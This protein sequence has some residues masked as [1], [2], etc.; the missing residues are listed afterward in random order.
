MTEIM[1]YLNNG[2]AVLTLIAIGFA[3]R[4]AVLWFGTNVV[5]PM[6]DAALSH[7]T[8]V[9]DTMKETQK[10]STESCEIMKTMHADVKDIKIHVGSGCK[11]R[12]RESG[13]SGGHH[14]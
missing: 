10:V 1:T 13:G 8:A 12:H 2:L 5:L 4:S 7:L 9:S 6:K 11:Y 14:S 3:T